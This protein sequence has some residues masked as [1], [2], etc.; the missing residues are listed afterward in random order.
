MKAR[1]LF[2]VGALTIVALAGCGSNSDTSTSS[3]SDNKPAAA[4]T[5]AAASPTVMAGQTFGAGCSA[6]PTDPSNAGSFSAMAKAPVATAASGNPVLSTLVSA[7]TKAGLGDSLNNASNIT[8]F[9]PYND[10]FAKIPANTLNAVLA[11][12]AKLE[13]ILTYHVV[14]QPAR[15]PAG[16]PLPQGPHRPATRGDHPGY[17]GG[18]TYREVADLLDTA[19]QTVKTR[20]RDGLIRLRDCL[21]VSLG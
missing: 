17:Y 13:Q 2:A 1:A 16:T 7:V 10:A 19:L 20:M 14:G 8:V 18:H 6:V 9:A 5:T 12:Q 15:T 3:S 21:G 11:D 4:M